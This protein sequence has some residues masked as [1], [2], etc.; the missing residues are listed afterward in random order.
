MIR[1]PPSVFSTFLQVSQPDIIGLLMQPA[2]NYTNCV[3]YFFHSCAFLSIRPSLVSCN[4]CWSQDKHLT[5]FWIIMKIQTIQ[6]SISAFEIKTEYSDIPNSKH[7]TVITL[8]CCQTALGHHGSFISSFL[9]LLLP[10]GFGRPCYMLY[11]LGKKIHLV[12]PPEKLLKWKFSCREFWLGATSFPLKK[13]F[14][15]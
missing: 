1:L 14:H 6:H 11:T 7:F 5:L 4:F 12:L 10:S 3:S 2:T 9:W 15:R 13:H 8:T